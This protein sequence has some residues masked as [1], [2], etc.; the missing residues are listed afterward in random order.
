MKLVNKKDLIVWGAVIA[1]LLS[2]VLFLGRGLRIEKTAPTL[3]AVSFSG[4]NSVPLEPV[5]VES[6]EIIEG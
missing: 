2:L 6:V 1:V 5:I 4:E 3:M